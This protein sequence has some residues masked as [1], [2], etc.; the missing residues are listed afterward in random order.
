M[1]VRLT[2]ATSAGFTRVSRRKRASSGRPIRRNASSFAE[3]SETGMPF[4]LCDP[5]LMW[6]PLS[7]KELRGKAFAQEGTSSL[8]SSAEEC[9][10]RLA[11]GVCGMQVSRVGW[12]GSRE[13]SA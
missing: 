1:S 8:S 7:S 6:P 4:T 10:A 2:Q 12:Q 9:D 11:T 3:S 5:A 13:G